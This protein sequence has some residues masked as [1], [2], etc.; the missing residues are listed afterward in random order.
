MSWVQ[1][2]WK[3]GLSHRVLRKISELES[4]AE[5]LRKEKHQRALQLESLEASLTKHKQL[6]DEERGNS[7]S[8]KRELQSLC[9]QNAE[10][11]RRSQKLQTEAQAKE[12]KFISVESQLTNL[13]RS[14]E[15]EQAS[16]SKLS[17]ELE[18]CSQQREDSSRQAES[19][20]S[21]LRK[22]EQVQRATGSEQ[23]DTARQLAGENIHPLLSLRLCFAFFLL[24]QLGRLYPFADRPLGCSTVSRSLPFFF[25]VCPACVC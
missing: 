23:E 19:L 13:K 11:Q 1:D 24:L 4:T 18:R 14:L 7:C 8:L 17:K 9:N 22:R 6:V 20:R 2:E 16:N 21:E 5:Q 25:C 12:N 15:L 10:L 3:D